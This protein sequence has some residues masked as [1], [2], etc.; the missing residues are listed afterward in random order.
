MR[1]AVTDRAD[2]DGHDSRN[3]AYDTTA[4]RGS[5]RAQP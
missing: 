2:R 4:N 5:R 1:D 3:H